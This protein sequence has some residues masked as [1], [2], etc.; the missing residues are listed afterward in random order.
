MAIG[1]CD[2]RNKNR[3]NDHVKGSN[4]SNSSGIEIEQTNPPHDV[5][6][7]S[8]DHMVLVNDQSVDVQEISN[9]SN[10][11]SVSSDQMLPIRLSLTSSLIETPYIP[12]Q[13]FLSNDEVEELANEVWDQ[14]GASCLLSNDVFST[15]YGITR[16][17]F[18][19]KGY[20]YL[21][22]PS[23]STAI[24]SSSNN[25]NLS[26]LQYIKNAKPSEKQH[27][28]SLDSRSI[29]WAAALFDTKNHEKHSSMITTLNSSSD[30]LDDAD[31][32]TI[33]LKEVVV[34]TSA[35]GSTI[36]DGSPLH[37][38]KQQ[39]SQEI[40]IDDNIQHIPRQVELKQEDIAELAKMIQ[41][42]VLGTKLPNDKSLIRQLTYNAT[43]DYFRQ[44][45]Y[46]HVDPTSCIPFKKEL[47]V[48]ATA[49]ER[50]RMTQLDECGIASAMVLCD[51]WKPQILPPASTGLLQSQENRM[52][53]K[54]SSTNKASGIE[55]NELNLTVN[56]IH[57]TIPADSVT[58]SL[59]PT[60]HILSVVNNDYKPTKPFTPVERQSFIQARE[61][62]IYEA[63][64]VI[65]KSLSMGAWPSPY[66]SFE[67]DQIRTRYETMTLSDLLDDDELVGDDIL[68]DLGSNNN[69][70]DQSLNSD[71]QQHMDHFFV[72]IASLKQFA[73][74]VIRP[75]II[76]DLNTAIAEANDHR[77]IGYDNGP[78]HI[79]LSTLIMLRE[80]M[81]Q[82]VIEI[83]GRTSILMGD[84]DE[85]LPL[86]LRGHG[87][88]NSKGDDVLT[89][90]ETAIFTAKILPTAVILAGLSEVKNDSDHLANQF[91]E[92]ATKYE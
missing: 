68:E 24:N 25:E 44:N 86:H 37:T 78:N 8:M 76:E 17:Y 91:L 63:V 21:D 13:V 15:K 2:G 59:D 19:Q 71:F 57:E 3:E 38:S 28:K 33:P 43:R 52:S 6:D 34:A 54:M 70:I 50:Q 65:G 36:V 45:G 64:D 29:A 61:D 77:R 42:A 1:L 87:N 47:L 12:H 80:L 72:V 23:P 60:I 79:L 82:N 7:N 11:M 69:T 66:H 20:L 51:R 89:S 75:K 41:D 85:F 35:R 84:E 14:M 74:D 4:D 16:E 40:K 46:L 32:N 92:L 58:Q 9:E 31:S 67:P 22:A 10:S 56:S 18:R 83:F 49:E 39:P 5:V 27:L 55:V 48:N 73:Q 26:K 53:D 81:A 62:E 88:H 90:N 30:V